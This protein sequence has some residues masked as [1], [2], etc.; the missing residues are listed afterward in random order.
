MAN[1]KKKPSWSMF[2]KLHDDVQDL[3]KENN[4]MWTFH[5]QKDGQGCIDTY[6]THIMGRFTC[7]RE[8]CR[9]PGWGSKKVAILIRRYKGNRYNA[10]VYHQR[11]ASCNNLSTPKPNASYA[12]RVAY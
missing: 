3:L 9:N 8:R 1:T 12:E 7:H 10:V 2:P 5:N 4:L 11:C 6:S